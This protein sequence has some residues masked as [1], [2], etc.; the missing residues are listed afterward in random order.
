LTESVDVTY[1]IPATEAD[2]VAMQNRIS[3]V[4][5]TQMVVD[6]NSDLVA[7][8][9]IGTQITGVSNVSALVEDE[10]E[11]YDVDGTSV[12]GGSVAGTMSLTV[13]DPASF[14]TNPS[15]EDAVTAAIAS[16]ASVSPSIVMVTLSQITGSVVSGR[17]LSGSVTAGYAILSGDP[18]IYGSMQD[19]STS[20]MMGQINSH[21]LAG[22]L[23]GFAVLAV[24]DMSSPIL[25]E[26]GGGGWGESSGAVSAALATELGISML[27][28]A[29]SV[30]F[31]ALIFLGIRD[32]FQ[33]QENCVGTVLKSM[34][35]LPCFITQVLGHIEHLEDA[36]IVGGAVGVE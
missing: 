9:V 10:D 29:F 14:S 28:A 24:S 15:V 8:G 2:A 3:A 5:V 34:C 17:R 36:L 31:T 16:V 23:D 32:K 25:T 35:C 22:G 11:D 19:C 4:N 26:E 33:I 12:D 7:N 13:A 30:A 18:S 6:V 27:L 21:L 1:S 20:A